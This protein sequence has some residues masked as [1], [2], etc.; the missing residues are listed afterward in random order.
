M[1]RWPYEEL[2]ESALDS[3]PRPSASP[4]I[5]LLGGVIAVGIGYVVT[6]AMTLPNVWAAL[7]TMALC[8]VLGVIIWVAIRLPLVPILRTGLLA[9]FWFRL[10]I[11]LLPLIKQGHE[12]PVGLV[13]SLNILLSLMLLVAFLYERRQG[14]ETVRVFPAAFSWAAAMMVVFSMFSVMQSTEKQFGLYGLWWQM[15]EL[16]LCFV[17]AAQFR[18]QR[19]LRQFVL[20]FAIA[21]LLNAILGILQY[22]ELFS[23]WALLGATTGD[24]LMKIPGAEVSRASG[25]TEAAN[26]F[27]WALVSYCPVIL[28][29]ALLAQEALPRWGRWL[30]MTAFFGGSIALLLTFSRG[31][32]VA[33][34][35]TLPVFAVMVLSA[36]PARERGRMILGLLGAFVALVLC[37]LPFLQPLSA[38]LLGDD[39]GAAETR[40]PLMEVATA[41]IQDHPILGVGL[42]NY[43][44]VMRRYDH[45]ADFITEAF[46][47]PVHNLYLHVAAEAGLPVLLCLLTM[48][49]IA[50]YCGWK[51]WRRTAPEMALPR[52]L[53]GGLIVGMLAYLIT[54]MK[55][56]G[57]FDSGQ[58]RNL[59]FLCGLLIATERASRP[60]EVRSLPE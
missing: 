5:A 28:A 31:S 6:S 15:T 40:L 9:S 1:P 56:P 48:V 50:M 58:I 3:A 60:M 54:A 35:L 30:C 43:E 7:V 33:F 23:G 57:S 47:Y 34:V 27:G 51:A 39:E 24:R 53:A 22:L 59:F 42:S 14:K 11:N 49:G 44:A 19:T 16:L 45:T 46:P 12:T 4:L 55:E 18:S 17:G 26:S 38:R 20:V 2:E 41:M 13:V 52:A 29:P 36:L 32:W 25:L 21:I 37:I 8:G 10:E